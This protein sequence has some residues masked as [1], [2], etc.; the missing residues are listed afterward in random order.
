MSAT[1]DE[2]EFFLEKEWSD[3]F[4]VVTP[5]EK[6]VQSM[7]QGTR[8]DPSDLVAHVPPASEP[9][10]DALIN[11]MAKEVQVAVAALGG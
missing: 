7:L 3:G 10:T 4:P 2:F 9:A 8:R 1:I 11:E 5:T 6:R